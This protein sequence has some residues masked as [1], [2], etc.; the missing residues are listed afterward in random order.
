MTLYDR[1]ARFY[2]PWS[3]S[4]VED[5]DFYLRAIR[6]GGCVFLNRIVLNYRT[7]APSLMHDQ[8]DSTGAIMA[9]QRMFMKYREK[10]GAFEMLFLKVLARIGLWWT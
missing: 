8:R 5:V 6:H 3:R 10:Y 9:Y 1:I 4:V 2:D 7:G